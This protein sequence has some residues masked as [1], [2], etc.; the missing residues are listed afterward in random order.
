L[1]LVLQFIIYASPNVPVALQA[2]L[3][4]QPALAPAE[5]EV[6][7]EGAAAGEVVVAVAAME[8]VGIKPFHSV[9]IFET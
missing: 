6:L 8:G 4:E 7:P 2:L 1:L 9:I 3:P 5:E